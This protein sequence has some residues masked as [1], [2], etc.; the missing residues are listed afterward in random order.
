MTLP[1][2]EK[3]AINATREFLLK[4]INPKETP[5]V[6]KPIRDRVY[7]LLKHYPCKFVVDTSWKRKE[8]I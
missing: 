8:I 4:L 2:E 5:R 1:F 3:N 6:P 7:S